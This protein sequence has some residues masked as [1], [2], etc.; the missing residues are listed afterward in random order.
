MQF[1]PLLQL[2]LAPLHMVLRTLQRLLYRQE[3]FALEAD[4]VGEVLHHT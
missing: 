3:F 1:L 4:Q 2:L